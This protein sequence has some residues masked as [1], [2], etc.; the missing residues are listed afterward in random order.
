VRGALD[1]VTE[2]IVGLARERFSRPPPVER[3]GVVPGSFLA[4]DVPGAVRQAFVDQQTSLLYTCGLTS[5]IPGVTDHDKAAIRVP[6]FVGFG[7]RDLTDAYAPA[8]AR[9]CA[10]NDV[11]RFV[12]PGSAHCHNQASTRMLL[13]DR[14]VAWIQSIG[15]TG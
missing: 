11:T 7:D 8:A 1:G 4:E 12:L 14:I 15:E 13:W 6:V 9:Y 2:R 5:M 10:S 3:R